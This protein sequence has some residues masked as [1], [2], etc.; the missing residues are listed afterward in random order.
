MG[1]NLDASD[2]DC[3]FDNRCGP[4]NARHARPG[5]SKRRRAK[6]IPTLCA[7]CAPSM[8]R[9]ATCAPRTAVSTAA[10][11]TM[12]PQTG[13]AWVCASIA[14]RSG[15]HAKS[16]KQRMCSLI[17]HAW[18]ACTTCRGNQYQASSCGA[19]VDAVCVD[20][21]TRFG[22]TCAACN[23]TTCT[24]CGAGRYAAASGVCTGELSL[25]AHAR[26]STVSHFPYCRPKLGT[27]IF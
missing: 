10:R 26:A 9:R 13:H 8:V 22:S 21:S 7:G 1:L 6:P 5:R 19:A 23:A 14:L 24:D 17:R 20:C 18:A 16:S 27:C 12:R 25:C 2:A 11:A 4:Q 15:V 3:R